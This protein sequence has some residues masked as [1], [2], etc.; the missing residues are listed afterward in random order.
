MH[1][2]I[3]SVDVY[4]SIRRY[5]HHCQKRAISPESLEPAVL[6]DK[7]CLFA[8]IGLLSNSTYF[9]HVYVHVESITPVSMRRLCGSLVERERERE[10]R[11][12]DDN[13]PAAIY[14][15]GTPTHV[16]ALCFYGHASFI[17]LYKTL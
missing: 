9:E 3:G 10:R 13:I 14:Y 15:I 5:Y 12:R 11:R 16:F 6:S 7:N 4:V 8:S 17:L 1:V 2:Y